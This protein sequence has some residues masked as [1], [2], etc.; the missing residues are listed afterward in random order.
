LSRHILNNHANPSSLTEF[1]FSW[2]KYYVYHYVY[3]Y[4]F[5]SDGNT[6]LK[7]NVCLSSCLIIH[8]ALL[9]K[10]HRVRIHIW[11]C[12]NPKQSHTRVPRD[13]THRSATVWN[14]P[15]HVISECSVY[16]YHEQQVSVLVLN[17]L[18][19]QLISL[20]NCNLNPFAKHGLYLVI[21]DQSWHSGTPLRN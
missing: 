16:S 15:L 20:T 8:N 3:Y 9:C 11:L 10:N 1:C 21:D 19:S 18:H 7:K 2:S 6:I 14:S 4:S 13:K 12:V 5:I 17:W